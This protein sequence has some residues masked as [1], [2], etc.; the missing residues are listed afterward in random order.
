MPNVVFNLSLFSGLFLPIHWNDLMIA[1]N[2]SVN[3][4]NGMPYLLTRDDIISNHA[5]LTL[6][7]NSFI[8]SAES[9]SGLYCSK[10]TCWQMV[11]VYKQDAGSN[12]DIWIVN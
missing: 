4:S 2:L 3:V 6:P 11:F 10:I 12:N 8:D 9:F 7:T 5:P 1:G